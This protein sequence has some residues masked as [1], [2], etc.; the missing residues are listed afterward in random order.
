MARRAPRLGMAGSARCEPLLSLRLFII[1]R[2]LSLLGPWSEAYGPHL[3]YRASVDNPAYGHGG[4]ATP[5]A[6][7]MFA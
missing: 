4:P 3:T 2:G 1:H 6:K 7:R 5:T